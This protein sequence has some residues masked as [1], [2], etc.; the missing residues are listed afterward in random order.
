MCVQ[1]VGLCSYCDCR[2]LPVVSRL[3]REHTTILEIS[4][5]LRDQVTSCRTPTAAAAPVLAVTTEDLFDCLLTLL[6]EHGSYEERS[7]YHELREDPTFAAT[8]KR[9][10]GEHLSIRQALIRASRSGTRSQPEP[11]SVVPVLDRLQGHIMREE[12]G[13]F[14]PAV[15]LLSTAAWER[16][17]ASGDRG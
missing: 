10:C 12:R 13:L 16:A 5:Q 3:S 9:F 17:E 6:A 15:I 7:L 2:T 4:G 11:E 1:C 14:P 8:A